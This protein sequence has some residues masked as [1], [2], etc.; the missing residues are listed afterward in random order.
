MSIFSIILKFLYFL[1]FIYFNQ[2]LSL[3][4]MSYEVMLRYFYAVVLVLILI[5]IIFVTLENL[6]MAYA[7]LKMTSSWSEGQPCSK[8]IDNTHCYD[9][10]AHYTHMHTHTYY[11]TLHSTD[12]NSILTCVY[13]SHCNYMYMKTYTSVNITLCIQWVHILLTCHDHCWKIIQ[14]HVW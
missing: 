9:L 11:Y 1:Y 5:I 7:V 3:Y 14:W 8:V 12:S 2:T 10:R 13:D 6:P 4:P